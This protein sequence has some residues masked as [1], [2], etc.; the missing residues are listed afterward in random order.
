MSTSTL[1]VITFALALVWYMWRRIK[2]NLEHLDDEDID[3]HT[4]FVG[5]VEGDF[6][7]EAAEF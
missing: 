6:I 1:V 3:I 2:G 7:E 5:G 4:A